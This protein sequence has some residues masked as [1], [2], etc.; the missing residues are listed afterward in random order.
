MIELDEDELK[1]APR[2]HVSGANISDVGVTPALTGRRAGRRREP[3]EDST[4]EPPTEEA[5]GE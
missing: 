3:A 4:D 2:A 5:A 1:P